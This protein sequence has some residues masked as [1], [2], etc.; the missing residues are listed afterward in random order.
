MGVPHPNQIH[1]SDLM[2]SA[3]WRYHGPTGQT[4]NYV[5]AGSWPAGEKTAALYQLRN[6]VN[7]K[8][9]Y[10]TEGTLR[11]MTSTTGWTLERHAQMAEAA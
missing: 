2:D 11:G 4:G 3:E 9:A 1:P 8:F 5:I 10:A 6:V 7:D